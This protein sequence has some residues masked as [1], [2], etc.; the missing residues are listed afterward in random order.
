[1]MPRFD[2]PSF[3]AGVPDVFAQCY[4]AIVG[5]LL[6]LGGLWALDKQRQTRAQRAS[7]LRLVRRFH[8]G[9]TR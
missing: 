1:M 9:G 3:L 6:I 7:R 8:D 2:L 4:P 5:V